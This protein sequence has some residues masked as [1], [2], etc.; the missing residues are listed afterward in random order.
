LA[1]RILI[2]DGR[3]RRFGFGGIAENACRSLKELVFPLL[4]L[5]GLSVEL[6]G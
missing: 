4:N 1:C 3:S 6:L 2:I 5:I